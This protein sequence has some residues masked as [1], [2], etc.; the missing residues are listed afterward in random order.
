[1]AISA[2]QSHE[3]PI[4]WPALIETALLA[5]TAVVM[6]SKAMR[7]V[8]I[9]YIH[10]RYTPLVIAC[11]VILA[12]IAGVRMRAIFGEAP[13]P[14]AGRKLSYLILFI[15]VLLGTIVPARPLNSGS[16]DLGDINAGLAGRSAQLEEDSTQW[17]LLQWATALS[18]RDSLE[19]KPADVI[20]FVAHD[21]ARPIDGFVVA[22][23][24]LTCCTADSSGVGL[25]VVWPGGAALKKDSWVRVRATLGQIEIAGEREPALIASSVEPVE[26]PLPPYV[27]P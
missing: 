6:L 14:L 27:Y 4:N 22:R 10:P 3:R 26:Q 5:G 9:Y 17:N 16:L 1:M 20:G 12:L 15:P 19:G 25:P 18:V 24:V 11:G 7:G 8:L 23:Y 2:S 21:P 13:Q